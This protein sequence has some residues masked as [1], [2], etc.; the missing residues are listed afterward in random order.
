[1]HNYA[2]WL[3]MYQSLAFNKL[4]IRLNNPVNGHKNNWTKNFFLKQSKFSSD[5]RSA[6]YLKTCFFLKCQIMKFKDKSEAYI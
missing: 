4:S 6:S 3:I 1:M 5:T 2:K